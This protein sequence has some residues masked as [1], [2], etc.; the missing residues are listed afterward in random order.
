MSDHSAFQEVDESTWEAAASTR[1]PVRVSP[2]EDLVALLETGAARRVPVADDKAL[3]GARIGIA[4]RASARGFRVEFRVLDGDLLV[5]RASESA[6]RRHPRT[7]ATP[8]AADGQ[9]RK[10]GRPPK[11]R[12]VE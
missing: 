7:Q 10:R 1:K 2:W 11:L 8:P 6:R 3:R 5:R 12:S 4:R 9:P